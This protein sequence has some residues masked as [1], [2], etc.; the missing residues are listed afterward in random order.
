MKKSQKSA[1]LWGGMI[2]ILFVSFACRLPVGENEPQ[3][4]KT[5]KPP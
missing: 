1:L 3:L 5:W 2:L 4:G